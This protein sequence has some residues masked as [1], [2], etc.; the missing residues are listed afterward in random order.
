MA[1]QYKRHSRGGR[2]K[3]Q[4]EG[5]RTSVDKIRQQR[6]TEIDAMKLQA[7]QADAISKLQISG[8][9]NVSKVESENR[10]MLQ[11]LE[12]EIYTKKRNAITVRSD[13]EVENLLGQAKELGKDA[14]WWEKFANTHSKEIGKA[15]QGLTDYAQYRQAVNAEETREPNEAEALAQNIND[16]YTTVYGDAVNSAEQIVDFKDS[17]AVVISAQGNR[18]NWAIREKEFTQDI[19]SFVQLVQRSTPGEFNHQTAAQHTV[20]AAYLYLRQHGIPFSSKSG[21]NIIAVAKRA[22]AQK[23]EQFYSK[24]TYDADQKD[25]DYNAEAFSA[26]MPRLIDRIE[27]AE[28][29]GNE[30]LAKKL[31]EEVQ[32][33]QRGFH[34]VINGSYQDLGQGKY[35]IVPRNPKEL[36]MEIITKTFPYMADRFMEPSDAIEFYNSIY[37]FNPKDGTTIIENGSTVGMVEKSKDIEEHIF[38]TV[39]TYQKKEKAKTQLIEQGRRVKKLEPYKD[40]WDKA[41][42]SGDYSTLNQEWQSGL[43][44]SLLTPEMNGTDEQKKAFWWLGYDK[45]IHGDLQKFLQ[46]KSDFESGDVNEALTGLAQIGDIPEGYANFHSTA[47]EI[48]QLPDEGKTITKRAKELIDAVH[49]STLV[50]GL[51]D[52]GDT[53]QVN[54]MINLATSRI[55]NLMATDTTEGKSAQAKFEDASTQVSK[56]IKEGLDGKGLFAAKRASSYKPAQYDKDGKRTKDGYIEEADADESGYYFLAADNFVNPGQAYSQETVQELFFTSGLANIQGGPQTYSNTYLQDKLSRNLNSNKSILSSDEKRNIINDGIRGNYDAKSIPDNLLMVVAMAKK[57]DSNVT[58]KEVMD[59]VLNGITEGAE[60]KAYSNV[61]WSANHEDLTKKITG[62]CT[63]NAKNN[64]ALC[65]GQLAKD[66]GVDLN[67]QLL[68]LFYNR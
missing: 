34:K 15:A 45:G 12:N 51:K 20:N 17:K 25:I 28:Q 60:F 68:K 3:N 32:L 67:T 35:G 14:A 33:V 1:Q 31:R 64:Y 29:G 43:L 42:E 62:S 46:I 27:T 47:V 4:G 22:G 6:Q 30:A 39:E 56:E 8:L 40:V 36:N 44:K 19:N 10:G 41:V 9:K 18:F 48:M 61:R 26:V 38:K 63:G 65:L 7:G 16:M 23:S 52:Y 59:M 50:A 37:T 21:R 53:N 5:L 54:T 11:K 57:N 58:T 55:I 13:R 66:K 49:D 2:F 24:V